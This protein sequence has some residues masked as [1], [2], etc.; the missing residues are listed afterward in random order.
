MKK[1][2]STLLILLLAVLCALTLFGCTG[3]DEPAD[4]GQTY[5][6]DELPLEGL[7]LIRK[8]VAQFRVVI[9]SGAGSEGRR[10]AS[11]LVN[12]LRELS[13]EIEDAVE[14]R[15]ATDITDCEIIIGVG[16][17]NREGCAVQASE[18]GE[19]GYV[20]KAVG[21]RIVIAGGTPTLTRSTVKAFIENQ[22]GITDDTTSKRNVAVPHELNIF[23]PT[24]YSID[25]IT[26]ASNDLSSY[27]I[28][29]DE[30]DAAVFPDT[31]NK[32]KQRIRQMSGYDLPIKDNRDVAAG[33]KR[34]IVR[35]VA[36][37]GE[38]GFRVYVGGNDLIIETSIPSMLESAVDDFL[39]DTFKGSKELLAFDKEYLYTKHVLTVTYA[40]FGAV[41][42]GKTND[43]FAML[44]AH[45]RANETGQTVIA[46]GIKGDTFYVGKTWQQGKTVNGVVDCDSSGNPYP[47]KTIDIKTNVRFGN[48]TV[49][50]DDTVEG[51]HLQSRRRA[52][53][54]TVARDNELTSYTNNDSK[55]K[56]SNLTSNPRLLVGDTSIPWLA[57]IL[58]EDKYIVFVENYNKK[59]FIRYGGNEN[60][61]NTRSD[62]LIVDGDGNISPET[63]VIFDF[64]TITA[65]R[66]SPVTDEDIV[67]S[68]GKFITVCARC[69][70][71]HE[72]TE[73][74]A[75]DAYARGMKIVRANATVTGLDHEVINEP[76]KK[77]Y[78]YTGF[79]YFLASYNSTF[80]NSKVFGRRY[81]YMA[82]SSVSWLMPMGTYDINLEDSVSIY[83]NNVTQYRDIKDQRYWG[84]C[85]SN[86]CKNLNFTGVSLSMIDA[87]CG[88]W[89]MNV[90]N[91]EIGYKFNVI[92]GGTLNV[93]DTV[94]R[95]GESFVVLRV[96]YGATFNGTMNFTNCHLNAYAAW[97]STSGEA[98]SGKYVFDEGVI[99]HLISSEFDPSRYYTGSDGQKRSFKEWDFGY[100]C[101]M[102]QYVNLD[103][104]TVGSDDHKTR[105]VPVRVFNDIPDASFDSDVKNGAY[106]LTKKITYK[107]MDKLFHS[108]A[109][110]GERIIRS[111]PLEKIQ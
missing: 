2:F 44:A 82:S 56:I 30:N 33:A 40:D 92:G 106:V 26:V 58:T 31:V 68:G 55:N 14:D 104:V 107:K 94:K 21:S 15:N 1:L 89:G 65:I 95:C 52:N 9:A 34:V 41:G 93:T 88:V 50:I 37:A 22:L 51:V 32:I 43:F 12:R 80:S 11:E 105:V 48:A 20:I 74:T 111:I 49:I 42:D 98:F 13:V 90:T 86:G 83:C 19:L 110:D 71:E 39:K 6:E 102:P 76:A 99:P 81:Y 100:R 103:N 85:T 5:P 45:N 27:V 7:V 38:D 101:Y 23:V 25:R 87:H 97:D 47:A 16:A 61:G 73:Y 66:F 108:S 79:I 8:N 24:D 96:D 78:P 57:P 46:E 63:P 84:V 10:A 18:L 91:C 59:D 72:N 69:A 67:I 109:P 70:P 28:A 60:Q 75:Y 54:F 17:K 29:C 62:V 53:I 4:D 77:S 64:D 36:D 35:T 3:G